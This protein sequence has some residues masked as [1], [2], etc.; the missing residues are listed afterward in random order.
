M[1]LQAEGIVAGYGP[2]EQILKG[3]TFAIDR[4]EIVAVI[5]PNGAGKSTLFKVLAGLLKVGSGSVR[6]LGQEVTD[7]P[8]QAL[9]RCGIAYVPQEHNVFPSLTVQENLELGGFI[10]RR[11][12]RSRIERLYAR[13]PL[14]AERRRRPARTLSG[15]QRQALAMAMA[16]MVDPQLLLLDEPSAGLAPLAAQELFAHIRAAHGQGVAIALVE[17]NALDA[18][19]LAHRAYILVDGRNSRSGPAGELSADPQVRRLFLGG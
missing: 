5:G 7:Q 16:L 3:I 19:A 14:L 9:A 11:E 18:L 8:P 10:D 1:L 12:R 2:G 13:F 4:A 6:F 15:G 17:Q